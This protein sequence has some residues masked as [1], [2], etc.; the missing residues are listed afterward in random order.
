MDGNSTKE[1]DLCLTKSQ[2]LYN[3]VRTIENEGYEP[4]WMKQ[5]MRMENEHKR[6]R[7]DQIHFLTR[8]SSPVL[9]L[10]SYSDH[11]KIF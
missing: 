5:E 3:R 11:S 2:S 8:V 7:K 6:K 1:S 10:P 9:D 4:P